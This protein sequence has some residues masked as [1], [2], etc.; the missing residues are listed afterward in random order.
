[1]LAM[2]SS[3]VLARSNYPA[4]FNYA[5]KYKCKGVNMGRFTN[6]SL[7][8]Y[9]DNGGF[10]PNAANQARSKAVDMYIAE[11]IYDIFPHS[12]GYEYERSIIGVSTSEISKNPNKYGNMAFAATYDSNGGLLYFYA[13]KG[14]YCYYFNNLEGIKEPQ[15]VNVSDSFAIPSYPSGSDKLDE[16]L[17]HGW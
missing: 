11:S 10:D 6:M 2:Q 17:T 13:V 8:E 15:V 7:A 16:A 4:A 9:T 1:M 3:T 14:D 5:V 12:D